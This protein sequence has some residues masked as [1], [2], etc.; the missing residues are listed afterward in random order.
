MSLALLI[1]VKLNKNIFKEELPFTSNIFSITI[2]IFKL[3]YH[4]YQLILSL[5][6]ILVWIFGYWHSG[7]LQEYFCVCVSIKI[8]PF[9]CAEHGF[10]ILFLF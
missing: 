4:P 10:H 8:L 3:K 9:R 6:L 2:C 5:R 1:T 7:S